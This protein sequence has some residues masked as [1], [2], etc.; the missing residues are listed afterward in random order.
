[1]AFLFLVNLCIIFIT[2]TYN[3]VTKRYIRYEGD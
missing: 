3:K 2:Y 1:M